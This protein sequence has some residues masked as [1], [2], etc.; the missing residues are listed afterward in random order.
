MDVDADI[1]VPRL[2]CLGVHTEVAIQELMK[3]LF[4]VSV[5]SFLPRGSL[6]VVLRTCT[7]SLIMYHR[8]VTQELGSANAVATKLRN[9]A[10]SALITDTC[11]PNKSPESLLDDWSDIIKTDYQERNPEIARATPDAIQMATVMNQQTKLMIQMK[12]MMGDMQVNYRQHSSSQ[13]SAISGLQND[14]ASL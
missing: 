3:Q 9:S 10:R 14:V 12:S 7:A 6:H 13:Q 5:P 1:K 11:F 2:E 8:M 4:V